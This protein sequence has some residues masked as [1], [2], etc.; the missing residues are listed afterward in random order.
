[1][2]DVDS[3]E[4][5]YE[6]SFDWWN[7]KANTDSPTWNWGVPFPDLLA[8]SR[9]MLMRSKYIEDVPYFELPGIEGCTYPPSQSE[10]GK[11]ED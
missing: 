8:V 10:T 5:I 2:I 4:E 11:V 9:T 3:G 6:G 7:L 1:M